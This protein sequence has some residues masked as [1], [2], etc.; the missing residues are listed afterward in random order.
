MYLM[1]RRIK[2]LGIKMVLSGEGADEAF[3]GYLYFHRAPSAEAFHSETVRKLMALHQYDCLRANK[4]MAAWGVEAR[5][6]F[7]DADFL[8]HVMHLRT[9]DKLTNTH[10]DSNG[11]NGPR[12]EKWPLRHAFDTSDDPYLPE[13]FLWRR[14]EQFSDGVGRAHA[15]TAVTDTQLHHARHRFPHNPPTTKEAYL[16]RDL[17]ARHFP[18]DSAAATVPGGRSIA[19]STEEALAWDASF[20]DMAD[21]SGRDLARTLDTVDNDDARSTSC[22]RIE[23]MKKKGETVSTSSV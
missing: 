23:K 6:P 12:M 22:K 17:F 5:V 9:E 3:G 14:K 1:S 20:A 10:T 19:C 16:Y 11:N 4:A 8:D 13:D 2:S 18:Q 15:E 7:L 21:P